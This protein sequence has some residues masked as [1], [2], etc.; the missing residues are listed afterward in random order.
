MMSVYGTASP[1]AAS[2][3]SA[4]LTSASEY[5]AVPI[6]CR[7]EASADCAAMLR[8]ESATP[9]T[10]VTVSR[11]LGATRTVSMMSV[12]ELGDWSPIDQES[13]EPVTAAAG[14]E[15]TKAS[16]AASVSM[17]TTARAETLGA[18]LVYRMRYCT[19]WPMLAVDGPMSCFWRATCGSSDVVCTG[20]DMLLSAPI[21]VP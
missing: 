4:R 15:E 9:F 7:A 10:T 18:A 5:D 19:S 3:T 1:I 13:T 17:T 21:G 12:V 20:A 8:P 6:I 11:T 2:R 14:T 16:P